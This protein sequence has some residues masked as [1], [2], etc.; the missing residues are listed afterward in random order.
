MYYRRGVLSMP[1]VLNSRVTFA[2]V[3]ATYGQH[4]GRAMRMPSSSFHELVDV[5]RP[6]LPRQGVPAAARTAIAL[7]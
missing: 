1:S 3:H 2:D 6:Q 7:R 4:C 5:L